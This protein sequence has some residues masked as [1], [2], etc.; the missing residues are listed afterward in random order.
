[1]STCASTEEK[2]TTSQHETDGVGEDGKSS[3]DRGWVCVGHVEQMDARSEIKVH[4]RQ[5]T[6]LRLV[7]KQRS[8]GGESSDSSKMEK[9][10]CLDSVC[11]HAGGPLMRG[12][13]VNVGG[14]T[15]VRCPWHAYLVDAFTGEGLYMDLSRK[16]QSKGVRQRVHEVEI[17]DDHVFVRLNMDGEVPSD[18]YAYGLRFGAGDGG[19]VRCFPDW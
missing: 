10:T 19:S 1:M 13:V 11:Y 7:R 14:R 4:G 9:W 17:R 18:E 3:D 6:V 5:V 12:P 8:G 16:Y 2:E 15:C